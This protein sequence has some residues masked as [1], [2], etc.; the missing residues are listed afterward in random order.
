MLRAKSVFTKIMSVVAAYLRAKAVRLAVYLDDW[1]Q[2]NQRRALIFK[3]A[4][5]TLNLLLDLGFIINKNKSSLV[6]KQVIV[7]LRSLFHLKRGLIFPT[8]E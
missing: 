3:E 1:L 6:P 8:K 2:L 5:M 7:Y 4:Q